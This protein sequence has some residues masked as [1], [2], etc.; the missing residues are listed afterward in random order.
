M[1]QTVCKIEEEKLMMYVILN[2]RIL[3]DRKEKNWTYIF[4]KIPKL[5]LTF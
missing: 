2:L 3:A 5:G 1:K 4:P